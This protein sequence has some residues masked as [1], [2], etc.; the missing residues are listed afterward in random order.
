M[1]V[2]IITACYNRAD[3][4]R[5]TI[6]SVLSQDYPEIEYIVVDGASS[7]GTVTIIN[8]YGSRIS[9]VLSEPDGGMYDALN[10][11]IRMATG[12]IV[13][14]LH[15]DDTFFDRHVVSTVVDQFVRNKPELLYGNGF[16]IDPKRP[17]RIIRNWVSG[18]MQY[19]RLRK[20]WLP[21]HTTVFC[22]RDL[23]GR[24]G[25]YLEDYRIAADTE[26]L[27]R[28]LYKYKVKAYYLNQYLVRMNMGGVSTSLN[29]TLTKWREDIRVYR[30]HGLNPYLALPLKILSK[31]PQFLFRSKVN[32]K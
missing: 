1:T 9:K 8:S 2:S 25:L 22:K 31:V 21:L 5:K 16:F 17:K 27:L 11:G 23:F 7:D 3:T 30:T 24:Y 29:R 14:V 15:S 32:R 4:I 12:D 26:L 20:G 28:Y 19:N 18:S 6:D 13:G 10:K